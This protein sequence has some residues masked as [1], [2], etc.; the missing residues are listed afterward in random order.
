[1]MQQALEAPCDPDDEATHML[2]GSALPLYR[3]VLAGALRSLRPGYPV[4]SVAPADLDATVERLHP[5]LV[6]CSAVSRV[7]EELAPAWI[8]LNP[9]GSSH[10]VVSVSGER[11]VIP[12]PTFDELVGLVDA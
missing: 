5:W 7:V 12:H 8:E 9:D 3:E 10:S 4:C 6:I 1:M 11:R 2:I